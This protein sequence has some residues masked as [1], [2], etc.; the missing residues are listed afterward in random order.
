[1]TVG[2]VMREIRKIKE[3]KDT[4]GRYNTG[5]ICSI[6]KTYTDEI[7]MLLEN[8][9]DLLMKLKITDFK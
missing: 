5:E 6:I 1:M 8:Y 2:S 3:A 4:I 7:Y 9:E